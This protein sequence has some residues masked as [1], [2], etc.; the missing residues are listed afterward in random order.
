MRYAIF[1]DIHGNIE[2][3][4]AVIKD[5]ESQSVDGFLCLG[6][7][8]GYG[9]SPGE[10]LRKVNDIGVLCVAGNHD[11]VTCE[12][13]DI[14]QM[15]KVARDAVLW[16]RKSLSTSFTSALGAL[17]LKLELEEMTLAHASLDDPEKWPYILFNSDASRCFSRQ[18]TQMAFVGHSHFPVCFMTPSP[19]EG[20]DTHPFGSVESQEIDVSDPVIEL[21]DGKRYI[22]NP[23]SVGQPRDGDP[24][25]SYAIYDTDRGIIFFKRTEYDVKKAGKKILDAG[26]PPILAERLQWGR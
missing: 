23:G 9:A 14:S 3:F 24:R 2:A 20:S 7:T 10:C 15:T 22:I 4:S 8:V 26:L 6:D 17:P 1:A 13:D 25:S 11:R 19:G 21:D 18:K 16:T 5:L 12:K